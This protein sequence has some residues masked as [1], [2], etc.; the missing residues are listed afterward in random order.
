[1]KRDRSST[2]LYSLSFLE[3][4]DK[5]IP[6]EAGIKKFDRIA[7]EYIPSGKETNKLRERINDWL[8][9]EGAENEASGPCFNEWDMYPGNVLPLQ[10]CLLHFEM[11]PSNEKEFYQYFIAISYIT[12][13]KENDS[14]NIHLFCAKYEKGR[15]N[16]Y[17]A[18]NYILNEFPYHRWTL[19]SVPSAKQFWEQR[20]GFYFSGERDNN[21]LYIGILEAP[22][23]RKVNMECAKCYTEEEE[24]LQDK[25][26]GRYFCSKECFQKLERQYTI[27]N[28]K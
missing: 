11:I 3:V 17:R 20:F 1:M 19:E 4:R 15:Q 9:S 7:K 16:G 6:E 25:D 22:K 28:K 24:M 23:M 27:R 10:G 13:K 21:D 2:K 18:V 12:Y 14:M 26:T 8:I 5:L